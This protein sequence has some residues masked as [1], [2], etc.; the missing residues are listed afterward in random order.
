[1]CSVC[2]FCLHYVFWKVNVINL[3]DLYKSYCCNQMDSSPARNPQCTI[4]Y[5]N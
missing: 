2:L 5:D 1:M 4:A 3:E